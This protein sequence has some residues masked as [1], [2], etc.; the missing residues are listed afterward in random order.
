LNA[1]VRCFFILESLRLVVDYGRPILFSIGYHFFLVLCTMEQHLV[2]VL[3]ARICFR[4]GPCRSASTNS[5]EI[6]G[7]VIKASLKPFT[8]LGY[9][10]YLSLFLIDVDYRSKH[11]AS[12]MTYGSLDTMVSNSD[13]VLALK[14][15]GYSS[16]LLGGKAGP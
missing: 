5:S 3:T 16:V 2:H 4:C 6:I 11:L 13:T 9:R 14:R 8:C 12:S 1:L 10:T 15:Q 7:F